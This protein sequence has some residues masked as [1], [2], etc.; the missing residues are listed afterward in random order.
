MAWEFRTVPDELVG[1]AEALADHFSVLG[2][3]V[4]PE[5]SS[6]DYPYTPTLHCKRQ[7][8]TL[9]MEVASEMPFDKVRDW[10]AYGRS[11]TADTR[12]VVG[13]PVASLVTPADQARLGETGA[14]LYFVSDTVVEALN[15]VD[16]GINLDPP[17]LNRFSNRVRK[18][19]GPAYENIHRGEWQGGFEEACVSMETAARSYLNKHL[20][21]NRIRILKP[22]GT[23]RRLTA[24]GVNR[25]TIGQLKDAYLAI[26]TP[27]GIDAKVATALKRINPDRIRVAHKKRSPRQ[28]K[29]LRQ[30]VGKQM[31][32]IT[33]ALS[34]LLG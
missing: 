32:I 23:P 4:K 8:K 2:Y 29:A 1:V 31:W 19:L 11:C 22:D 13:L 26:D 27:N 5:K 7:S 30:N 15:A 16:L 21:T 14:G 18:S 20:T 12:V 10:V 9:F 6:V 17:A 25:M 28:E 3:T 24:A 34:E 33:N